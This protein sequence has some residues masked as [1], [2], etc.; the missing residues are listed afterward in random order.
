MV[1]RAGDG[2]RVRYRTMLILVA[3]DEL[4]GAHDFID[5]LG[6]AI[7][8]THHARLRDAVTKAEGF[9]TIGAIRVDRSDHLEWRR[10]SKYFALQVGEIVGGAREEPKHQM[11][12][13]G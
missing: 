7:R 1:E 10:L 11:E 9:V 12:R 2:G 5:S 3:E 6:C 13:P 8:Q 4:A